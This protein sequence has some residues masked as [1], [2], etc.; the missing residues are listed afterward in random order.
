LIASSKKRKSSNTLA[1]QQTL[2]AF[3][4]SPR[5]EA[6]QETATA[7]P[8]SPLTKKSKQINQV[9]SARSN[10][11]SQPYDIAN[12]K[13]GFVTPAA[14]TSNGNTS[15]S[16]IL[17]SNL[18]TKAAPKKLVI[19]NFKGMPDAPGVCLRQM[20]HS[21]FLAVKPQLPPNYEDETWERL[22][23]AVHAIQNHEKVPESLETLYKVRPCLTMDEYRLWRSINLNPKN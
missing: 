11:M 6:F 21:M 1:N 14:T 22:K 9:E 13:L 20:H 3:Y 5:G 15:N 18:R 8:D 10:I 4:N 16:K 7:K 2:D 12:G 17:S 23:R 19:R